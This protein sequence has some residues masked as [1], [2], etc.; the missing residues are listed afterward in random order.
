MN[1]AEL[2]LVRQNL[3]RL[4]R[5]RLHRRRAQI[6]RIEEELETREVAWEDQAAEASDAALGDSLADVDLRALREIDAA[7]ARLDAG[8]YGAC[9][10]CRAPI[11]ESRLAAWPTA[12]L[13]ADCALLS[14]AR[15]PA[16]SD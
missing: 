2:D 1:T 14:E 7:L 16:H 9:A 11:D 5:Q 12:A 15:L 6:G 3:L 13:C 8:R 4:R 10:E